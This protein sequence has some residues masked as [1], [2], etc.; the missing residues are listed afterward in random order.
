VRR[1]WCVAP[2]CAC[3]VCVLRRRGKGTARAV[4]SVRSFGPGTFPLS[5]TF[6]STPPPCG[7]LPPIPYQRAHAH[8]P[9]PHTPLSPSPT[10]SYEEVEIE[11][12]EWSDELQAY[13]YACP[14]GDVFQ[15]TKV[16]ESG[17]ECVRARACCRPNPLSLATHARAV[18]AGGGW[19]AGR[20]VRGQGWGSFGR[21]WTRARG[22]H[23]R[24]RSFPSRALDSV[25]SG[26]L[27]CPY[28]PRL[29]RACRAGP[30]CHSGAARMRAHAPR[31]PPVA[32]CGAPFLPRMPVTRADAPPPPPVLTSSL[33][34]LPFAGGTRRRRGHRPL[35]LLL[36]HRPRHL[37][38]G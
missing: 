5:S 2:R 30:A 19:H 12:M 7:G 3:C 17:G 33:S 20:G 29:R 13:T 16:R 11:D 35:P 28:C 4:R 34:P 25:G 31:P 38:P 18:S 22:T 8:T 15:I 23:T 27:P 14:C 21:A 26:A 36:P 6:T 37:Q 32:R 9:H 10:M 24:A 1:R